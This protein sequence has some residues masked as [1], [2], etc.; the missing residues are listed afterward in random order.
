VY[1][2]TEVSG[3]SGMTAE[4]ILSDFAAAWRMYPMIVV[5]V[6]DESTG[7]EKAAATDIR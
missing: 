1:A 2:K 3:V 7:S 6:L 4:I 5:A